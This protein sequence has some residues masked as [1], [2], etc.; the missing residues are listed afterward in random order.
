MEFQFLMTAV[1]IS[2]LIWNCRLK[3]LQGDLVAGVTVALTLIP[4]SI[5]YAQIA[6]LDSKVHA[7]C[8]CSLGLIIYYQW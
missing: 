1:K 3:H 2:L 5:A 6:N 4:Q 8:T 7:L